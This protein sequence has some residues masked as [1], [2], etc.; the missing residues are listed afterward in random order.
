MGN[1][2]SVNP[3][4]RVVSMLSQSWLTLDTLC[5]PQKYTPLLNT[6]ELVSRLQEWTQRMPHNQHALACSTFD[7][8]SLYTNITWRNLLRTWEWWKRWYKDLPDTK[9]GGGG[10]SEGANM[11]VDMFFSPMDQAEVNHL[12]CFF[13]YLHLPSLDES[14]DLGLVLLNGVHMHVFFECLGAE[15]YRQCI[16]L[17]IALQL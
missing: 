9:F 2:T 8:R 15:V 13:P 3:A 7:F 17:A 6:M 5:N 4:Q 14:I 1:Y 16:G 12:K 11:Y 10:V